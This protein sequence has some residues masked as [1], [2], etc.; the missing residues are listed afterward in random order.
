MLKWLLTL[1]LVCS[2]LVAHAALPDSV[3]GTLLVVSKADNLVSFVD[4]GSGKIKTTLPTGQGPHELIVSEDGLWAV[5]SDFVGGNSLTI[6]DVANLSVARTIDL[7]AFPRP[8]G[9][10]FLK[11][12]KHVAATTG[13]RNTLIVADIHSG[14]IINTIDT[15]QAGTHMVAVD[16]ERSLAYTSNMRSNTLSVLDLSAGSFLRT[17]ATA[18][19]P[20]AIRLTRSGHQLWYGANR[21]G[22]VKVVNSETGTELAEWDGF[23]FPYRV[24]FS[25]DERV[26]VVPDFRQDNVRFFDPK[27]MTELGKLPLGNGAGPQGVIFHPND[28]TLFLSLNSKSKVVAIDADSRQVIAELDSGKNPDGIGYTALE[29]NQ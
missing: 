12:Q 1:L 14:K 25:R 9:I 6:I 26:A 20:E 23:T 21:N 22:Q 28:K 4:I 13:A 24:L 18:Q 2:G 5:V 29:F 16:T 8:H 7:K 17:I 11:N 15:T 19:T 27:N 10:Q 3:R